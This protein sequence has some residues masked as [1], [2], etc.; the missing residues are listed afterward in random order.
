MNAG[1]YGLRAEAAYMG[2][3]DDR[4][5]EPFMKNHNVFIVV[6]ADRAFSD[7]LNLNVQYMLRYIRQFSAS[8]VGIAYSG[9][10]HQLAGRAGTARRHGSPEAFM[11]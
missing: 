3:E 1:R 5:S 9:S 7:R 10:D 8:D 11:A 2:T 6:G 4:G